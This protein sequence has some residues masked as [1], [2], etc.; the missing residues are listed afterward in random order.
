MNSLLFRGRI[1]RMVKQKHSDFHRFTNYYSFEL[2][3]RCPGP[4]MQ[5]HLVPPDQAR[6]FKNRLKY[7]LKST[8]IAIFQKI[9]NQSN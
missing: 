4:D 6:V 5:G 2:L 3:Q 8:Q 7:N 9:Y 1:E